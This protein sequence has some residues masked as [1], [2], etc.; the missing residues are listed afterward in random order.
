MKT[1]DTVTLDIVKDSLLAIGDEIFYAFAQTSM[2]PII[3]ETLD[4]ACG[5]ANAEGDLLTQGNGAC[6]FIGMIAPMINEVIKKF[7]K[8]NMKGGD[9]FLINDPYMGGGTH[10][11][12]IGMVMP[13]FYQDEIVAFVGN[14]AHWVDVGGM[15]AGS[16]TTDSS[17]VYQEGLRFSGVKLIQAG[18]LNPAVADILFANV[19]NANPLDKHR[20]NRW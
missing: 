16:F 5:I 9:V 8:E 13:V 12:D 20:K 3:Y 1:I 17:D 19:R 6:G 10:L 2:S 15:A 4:Y 11:S 18:E 7:G 14:K